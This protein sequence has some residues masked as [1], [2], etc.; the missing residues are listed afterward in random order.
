MRGLRMRGAVAARALAALAA[1]AMLSASP[2]SAQD[3]DRAAIERGRQKFEYMCEPCHGA[4]IGDDGRAMLPGTDAL[5]IK[6]RGTRP[7]LLTERTDLTP[8][9]L[10]V[11]VR[12]GVFSMPP[13]RPTEITDEEIDEIAA[14]IRDAASRP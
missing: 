5:R 4:G 6:Y 1:A 14:Y 11:F 9:A 13:F 10:R 8:E 12:Q 7:A 2:A 3:G